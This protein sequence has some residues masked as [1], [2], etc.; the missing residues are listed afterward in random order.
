MPQEVDLKARRRFTV[1]NVVSLPDN[2]REGK[3]SARRR[4]ENGK[5]SA[6]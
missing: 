2:P 4:H 1:V 6:S 5:E 3:R